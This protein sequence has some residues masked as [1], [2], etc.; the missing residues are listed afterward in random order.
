M[1]GFFVLTIFGGRAMTVALAVVTPDGIVVAADSRTTWG[2]PGGQYRILSD[3]THKVFKVGDVAVTT[4]GWA[5]L[6]G[7]P[8]A[9]HFAEFNRSLSRSVSVRDV[10]DALADFMGDRMDEHLREGLDEPPAAGVDPLG[11]LVAG[12]EDGHGKTLEVVLPSRAVQEVVASTCGAAWRGQTDV[13]ERLI[14]GIDASSLLAA[15]ASLEAGAA[16]AALA[17]EFASLEYVIPFNSMNL[18]DGVDFAVLAIRTT[19]DMQRLTY[20]TFAAPDSWPG[21]GGPIEIAVVRADAGFSWLQRTA[22]QGERP[23]GDAEGARAASG[24]LD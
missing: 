15:C 20:G 11:F 5:L 4:Y 24:G 3:F 21:V 17:S 13:I 19:I 7:K 2:P 9:G 1:A 6:L 10:A 14:K 16:A 23:A 18:Q 8:I 12:Y 22:L